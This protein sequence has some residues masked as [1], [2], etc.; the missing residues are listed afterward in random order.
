[1][2]HGPPIRATMRGHRAEAFTRGKRSMSEAQR[3]HRRADRGSGA[4]RVSASAAVAITAAVIGLST[5]AGPGTPR[6]GAV[7][8]TLST[9]PDPTTAASQASEVGETRVGANSHTTLLQVRKVLA[10]TDRSAPEGQ[11]W[12]GIRA[13]TC[14]HADAHGSGGVPWAEWVVETDIGISYAGRRVPWTDFP[15]Q[16]YSTDGVRRGKCNVGWVLVAVPRGTFRD[17]VKVRFR[18][19]SADKPTWAV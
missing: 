13:R 3:G 7:D 11:E 18:P 12:Y 1:M 4:V 15:P 5:A 8:D 6:P 9:A 19:H 17:V 10:P 2:I 16:Q 14:M